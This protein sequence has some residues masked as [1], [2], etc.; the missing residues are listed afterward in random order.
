MKAV[1]LKSPKQL[2]YMNVPVPKITEENHVLVN[3]NACGICGSDL[4][5]WAGE[6]PWALHTLG[7]HVD[8]PANII[9]GHEFAGIVEKVNSQKY[10]NLLGQRVG[11]QTFRVCGECDFCRSGRENLCRRMMHIGHAQGWGEM[12]YYP[13]GY[14]DYCLGWA[15]LLHPI[16]DELSFAEAAM[17]DILCVAVHAVGRTRIDNNSTVFCIGGGPAGLAI[18]QTAKTKGAKKIYISDPSPI[19]RQ[20]LSQYNDF[21]ILDPEN[22]NINEI[23]GTGQC[24]AIFDSVGSAETLKMAL[25]LLQESGVLVNLA[26]HS[27]SITLNALS[28]GSE[29]CMTTSSNAFYRDLTEAYHLLS[30]GRI[31][32][33]PWITHRFPLHD[34]DKAFDLLLQNP[35]A[36][37]KVVFEP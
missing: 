31:D 4:R 23:V 1:V 34:Y 2:E 28:L 24:S 25:P 35:K 15:D 33:K 3:V 12:E 14:A 11:V 17:A 6:N 9:L 29:R 13:G 37:Y 8:N 5:Y 32:V 7:K 19:A 21:I 20:V 30:S 36:A 18:A 26:V 10:E 27:E 16:P 22:Q